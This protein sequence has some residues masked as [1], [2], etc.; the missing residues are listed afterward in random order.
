MYSPQQ[1]PQAAA[2]QLSRR[3]IFLSE[4]YLAVW[5]ER[6]EAGKTRTVKA[7]LFYLLNLKKFMTSH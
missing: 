1:G 7:R 3:E 4:K 5:R 6:V 2:Q